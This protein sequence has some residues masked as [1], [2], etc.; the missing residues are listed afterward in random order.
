M[1]GRAGAAGAWRER[2]AKD[3]ALAR[4]H[5]TTRTGPDRQC[6]C[7]CS[8]QHKQDGHHESSRDI[9]G[10]FLPSVG[11]LLEALSPPPLATLLSPQERTSRWEVEEPGLPQSRR[12]HPSSLHESLIPPLGCQQRNRVSHQASSCSRTG[13]DPARRALPARIGSH[14]ACP[15]ACLGRH[16]PAI[17]RLL[18]SL[19]GPPEKI[20]AHC[21]FQ[22]SRLRPDHT[23][24]PHER[25]GRGVRVAPAPRPGSRFP[26]RA[27]SRRRWVEASA[28]AAA[29]R[30][31]RQAFAALR[32]TTWSVLL[33]ATARKLSCYCAPRTSRTRSLSVPPAR[34]RNS[35][36]LR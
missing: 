21:G 19:P 4:R 35:A 36:S 12:L 8:D 20:P 5:G 15:G 2:G 10:V 25:R 9:H 1:D 3:W 16:K 31:S 7:A 17:C 28:P 30:Y 6:E 29:V 11:L 34:S 13:D 22:R 33:E 27:R 23:P 26:T 32:L 24:E 14:G 18:Q